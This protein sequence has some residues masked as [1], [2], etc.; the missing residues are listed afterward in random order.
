[1][2]SRTVAIIRIDTLILSIGSP[3]FVPSNTEGPIQMTTPATNNHIAN[4]LN[5]TKRRLIDSARES[6]LFIVSHFQGL[7]F[8]RSPFHCHRCL[9]VQVCLREGNFN[10]LFTKPLIEVYQYLRKHRTNSFARILDPKS[11]TEN[12][13]RI[14]KLNEEGLGRSICEDPRYIVTDGLHYFLHDSRLGIVRNT[15]SYA[16]PNSI[17]FVCPVLDRLTCKKIIRN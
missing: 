13:C 16:E 8:L 17:V 7:L 3:N 10:S 12:E 14:S 6:D 5:V 9:D 2:R 1:M 15:N 11:Q 4:R